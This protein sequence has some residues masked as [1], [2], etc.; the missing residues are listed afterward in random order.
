MN[1]MSGTEF[2]GDVFDLLTSGTGKTEISS[3][4]APSTVAKLFY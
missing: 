4:A 2:G 3:F 1:K